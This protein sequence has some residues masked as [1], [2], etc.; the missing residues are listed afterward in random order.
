MKSEKWDQFI[1]KSSKGAIALVKNGKGTNKSAQSS[2]VLSLNTDLW[3]KISQWQFG[4]IFDEK[5]YKHWE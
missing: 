2:L 5:P 1:N 4:R 3:G